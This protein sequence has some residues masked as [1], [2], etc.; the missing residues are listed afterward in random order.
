MVSGLHSAGGVDI[1]STEIRTLSTYEKLE[2]DAQ[3][4]RAAIIHRRQNMGHLRVVEPT[5]ISRLMQR[6]T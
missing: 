4:E 2:Q 1:D 6:Q 3:L 5:K